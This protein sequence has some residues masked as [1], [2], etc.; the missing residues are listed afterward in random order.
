[1][2]G[3]ALLLAF[4]ALFTV[5]ARGL[6][7]PPLTPLIAS[8]GGLSPDQIPQFVL[9]THDDGVNRA[10][11]DLLRSVTDGR[12][13]AN[14]CPL[15][16]TLFAKTAN[17][18]CKSL[19]ELYE[20]GYEVADHTV[21]HKRLLGEDRSFVE[22]ELLEARAQLAA[23]GVP[24][25]DIVGARMPFL[26][27]DATVRQVL[28][29]NGFLYDSSLVEDTLGSSVSQGF[30]NRLWP[31]DMAAGI[32]INCSYWEG[33]Y[34]THRQ[35]CQAG[36]AYPGLW[37]VPVW[38]M[39]LMAGTGPFHMDPGFD[40]ATMSQSSPQSALEIMVTH[41][42]AAYSGNRAPFGVYIHPFWMREGDNT[43]QLQQFADFALSLPGVYFVTMRQLI[44][45][46]KNPIP[47][48]QLTAEALGCGNPGG[49]GGPEP[50]APAPSPQRRLL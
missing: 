21:N 38:R 27:E 14:G 10:A 17:T 29:E 46:M 30:A 43:V 33:K 40:Y 16:A 8:P 11:K 31:F 35:E 12:Q 39:G 5:L 15:T 48:D 42:H 20:A 49:A 45:W 2:R 32:P 22:S 4:F 25:G 18:D 44:A 1:M 24:E 19:L 23:C 36:E 28:A 6:A 34:G 7:A 41:F 37:Q 50:P 9:L 47:A 13:T 26:D 3:S